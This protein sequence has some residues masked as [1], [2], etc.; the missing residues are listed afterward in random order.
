MAIELE[1]KLVLQTIDLV[2]AYFDDATVM[3]RILFTS[4]LE[5]E[6]LEILA[7]LREQYA[8]AKTIKVSLCLKMWS[9]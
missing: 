8:I 2:D 3:K 7:E 1:K 4:E 9:I 6:T 5:T